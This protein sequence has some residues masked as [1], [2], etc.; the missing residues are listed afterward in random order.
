MAR[1]AGFVASLVLAVRFLTILPIPGREAQGASA[2]GRAAWWFPFVGLALGGALVLV[3]R[4]LAALVPPLVAAAILLACWKILSGALHLDGLADCFDGLGVRDRARRLAVMRDSAVGVFGAAALV[5]ALLIAFSALAALPDPSRTPLLLLAPAIGRATPLL[6]GALARPATPG[7]GLGAPFLA[8]L[9]PAAA[10]VW[11]VS[12]LIIAWA[13]LG[14]IGI[15]IAVVATA[16]GVGAALALAR[17]LGGLT[18]DVL[19]AG[20]ELS[21]LATLV[22]GVACV[23]RGLA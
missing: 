7:Q 20:V 11:L 5:G 1:P 16:V 18:G 17:R 22:A 3:D 19:G 10:P 12:E 2:L 6:A 8:A 9:P 15:A 4:A 23:H 14:A 21:E 13:L